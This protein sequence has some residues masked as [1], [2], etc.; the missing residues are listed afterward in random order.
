VIGTVAAGG[1]CSPPSPAHRQLLQQGATARSP[2]PGDSE[3]SSGSSCGEDEDCFDS[4]SEV[5][6]LVERLRLQELGRL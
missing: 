6:S 2:S 1:A 5:N 4:D 3:D